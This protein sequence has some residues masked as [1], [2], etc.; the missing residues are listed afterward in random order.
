MAE[1]SA[2]VTGESAVKSGLLNGSSDDLWTDTD[3]ESFVRATQCVLDAAAGCGFVSPRAVAC[4]KAVTSTPNVKL[5]SS[6][7]RKTF[8]LNATPPVTPRRHVNTRPRRGT[9]T[10]SSLPIATSSPLRADASYGE[11][12]LAALVEPDDFLDSQVKLDDAPVASKSRN[13]VCSGALETSDTCS[14]ITKTGE[15]HTLLSAFC[16]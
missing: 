9:S 14:G 8:S 6:Q 11:E 12:L 3:D 15:H 13:P 1:N 4:S 5:S 2:S 16:K 10:I 7:C